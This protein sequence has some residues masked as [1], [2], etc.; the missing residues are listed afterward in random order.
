[1]GFSL[2]QGFCS[3]FYFVIW[4]GDGCYTACDVARVHA[5]LCETSGD[6]PHDGVSELHQSLELCF[7]TQIQSGVRE[8]C[9]EETPQQLSITRDSLSAGDHTRTREHQRV[10][11]PSQECECVHSMVQAC[12]G[13]GCL[14]QCEAAELCQVTDSSITT[15]TSLGCATDQRQVP[16]R[17]ALLGYPQARECGGASAAGYSLAQVGA[18]DEPSVT[19]GATLVQECAAADPE[20]GLELGRPTVHGYPQAREC[21]ADSVS[22]QEKVI[23]EVSAV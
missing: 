4:C 22:S 1:M 5:L 23:D 11:N 14:Q 17:T 16:E 7:A 10:T 6:E 15:A 12:A 3:F 9:A 19:A 13:A 2:S 20:F 21:A 8:L 18:G